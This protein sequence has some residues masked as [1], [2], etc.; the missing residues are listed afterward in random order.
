MG[1]SMLLYV[2]SLYSSFLTCHVTVFKC[3]VFMCH[4][5]KTSIGI[6]LTPCTLV[7]YYCTAGHY[8]GSGPTECIQ[9]NLQQS[10]HLMKGIT[11]CQEYTKILNDIRQHNYFI[12]RGPINDIMDINHVANK[13]RMLDTL[14]KCYIYKRHKAGVKLTINLQCRKI[15]SLRH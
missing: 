9:G 10:V 7:S 1:M 4:C 3:I 6:S 11:M 2:A 12:V 5:S 14:E 8:S 15:R 13:G